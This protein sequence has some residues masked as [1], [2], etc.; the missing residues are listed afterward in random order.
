MHREIKLRMRRV[1]VI[2]Q[3]AVSFVVLTTAALFLQNLARS[4]SLGP[5]FDVRDTIHADVYLPPAKYKESR[6]I[7]LFVLRALDGL[8][9]I[10]G[11]TSAAAARVVPFTDSIHYGSDVTFPD[12]GEKRH[13]Q[14]N[15]NAVTPDYFR[16]MDIPLLRGR[17]FGPQDNGATMVVMVNDV[18]VRQYLGTREPVGTTFLWG[19]DRAAHTI[20]GVVRVTKNMTIG[21]NPQP[22]L[23]EPLA[24][25]HNEHGTTIQFVIRS[26][27]PPPAEQ[28]APVRQTL[29]Q[30]EPSAGLEVETMFAAIGFAFLPSQVGAAL[31]GSVGALALFLSLIGLYGV[32]AYSITRRTREIGVR[33]AIGATP[34]QV[35]RLV[36]ADF[37]RM[38]AV[39]IGIGLAVS[40]LATRPL[41]IFFVPGLRPSD[42][43]SFVAVIAVLGAT[44]VLAAVGPLRRALRVDP[45]ECLRSE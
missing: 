32:L 34:T 44:G 12:N 19:P 41:A 17:A 35:S 23:Y 22:Q 16:A 26:A 14:F 30:A 38:L 3:I 18:F 28:I 7:N 36:L 39:G 13:M 4:S 1:L 21:E 2:A 43:A 45:L 37:A 20:V 25:I 10:P 27:M 42:P 5:G 9:A 8:R 40:L 31:M 11:V 15:W 24:Q 6:T 33:V 29:R